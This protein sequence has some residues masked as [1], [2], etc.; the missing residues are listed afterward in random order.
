MIEIDLRWPAA[1]HDIWNIVF[2]VCDPDT[3]IDITRCWRA[4]HGWDTRCRGAY[5]FSF[6]LVVRVHERYKSTNE[7]LV[8]RPEM[9]QLGGPPEGRGGSLNG[10]SSSCTILR[11]IEACTIWPEPPT[12]HQMVFHRFMKEVH[13][14]WWPQSTNDH[15]ESMW[16]WQMP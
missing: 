2:K 7:A 3:G 14:W 10:R 5:Q 12:S 4:Y 9:T 6:F 8:C 15:K 13:L 11:D 1:L 16:V